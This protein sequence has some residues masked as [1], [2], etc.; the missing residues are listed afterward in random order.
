MIKKK[1]GKLTCDYL[2]FSLLFSIPNDVIV[3]CIY[4]HEKTMIYMF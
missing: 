4:E 1:D 3:A 2:H